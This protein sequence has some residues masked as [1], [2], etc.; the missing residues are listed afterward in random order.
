[1]TIGRM[2]NLTSEK[3]VY[4]LQ[5]FLASFYIL[6]GNDILLIE[7]SKN[8]IL[9]QSHSLKFYKHENIFLYESIDWNR[10]FHSINNLNLFTNRQSLIIHFGTQNII[11]SIDENLKKLIS[12]SHNDLLCI[13]ILHQKPSNHTWFKLLNSNN[14]TVLV[15]CNTPK[16]E[17]LYHWILNRAKNLNLS[18][19]ENA[20]QLLSYYCENN[21]LA[22]VQILENL[23]L[24]YPDKKQFSTKHL[25]IVIN[26]Y[27]Q[28][29]H[30]KWVD[31][32]LSGEENRASY[33]LYHLKLSG[34]E[35]I[36]L[37][38]LIQKEILFLLK[39]KRYTI[40]IPIHKLFYK[41]NIWY[42][43]RLLLKNAL[44]RLDIQQLKKSIQFMEIIELQ[45]KNNENYFIWFHL[46]TLIILLS[47]R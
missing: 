11:S 46:H 38:R 17:K 7:E 42:D 26:D 39:L 13:F 27:S 20:C 35:P 18:L 25:K 14:T 31:A 3:L 9:K 32:V 5:N 37:L 8:L 10:L 40:N 15:N 33:I 23:L 29:T 45:Y 12:L 41:Y 28:F 43:R 4:Q 30:F 24:I 36:L 22:I 21:L 44:D 34:I 19:D 6:I 16:K 2:I 47:K 1:M